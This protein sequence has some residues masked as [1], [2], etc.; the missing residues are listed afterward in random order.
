MPVDGTAGLS[1]GP[2]VRIADADD[3]ERL[4]TI[5]TGDASVVDVVIEAVRTAAPGERSDHVVVVGLV[6]GCSP[7]PGLVRRADGEVRLVDTGSDPTVDCATTVTIVAV[8]E[9]AADDVPVGATDGA[10]VRHVAFVGY[11][12]MLPRD[13]LDLPPVAADHRRITAVVSGCQAT[14]AELVVSASSVEVV[15]R[16]EHDESRI[17]CVRAEYF[18][19]V[20]DIAAVWLP[21][22]VALPELA[23]IEPAGEPE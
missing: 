23:T 1:R 21:D 22:G 2:A 5:L 16:R 6:E 18:V 8:V 9:A 20:A 19:V 7:E 15:A 13:E 10:T 11:E 3:V 17:E 4:A 14:T 12:P